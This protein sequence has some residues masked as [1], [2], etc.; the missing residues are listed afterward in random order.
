M[1][2]PL[3][4]RI[5]LIIEDEPLIALDI[6]DA[7]EDAGAIAI[8]ARTLTAALV[9]VE[10]PSLSA[11]IVDFALSDEDSSMLCERLTARNIPFVTYSGS[12]QLD[13]A[14]SAG[15]HVNKP[16]SASVLVAT[17]VGLLASRPIS[18]GP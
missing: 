11:A 5:I 3:S 9:E 1:D 2:R 12:S 14:R 18:N 10:E 13:A 17:V 6:K 16:A 4:G 8:I 15:T 7:F